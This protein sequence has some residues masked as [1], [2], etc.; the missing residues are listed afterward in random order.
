MAKTA[1]TGSMLH[2]KSAT[3]VL[4]QQSVNI[5]TP[6]SASAFCK[7]DNIPF[8]VPFSSTVPHLPSNLLN[9]RILKFSIV[10]KYFKIS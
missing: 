5:A 7:L 10:E 4:R 6:I 1:D 3:S 2:K 8:D 9:S